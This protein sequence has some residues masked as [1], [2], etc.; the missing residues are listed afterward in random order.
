MSFIPPW[1]WLAVPLFVMAV[2]AFRYK[3]V[4][5]LAC[6]FISLI[7]ALGQSDMNL[8]ALWNKPVGY[9]ENAI[10]VFSWNSLGWRQGDKTKW[11]DYIAAHKADIIL[12]QE[13]IPP[14]T[15]DTPVPTEL[16][17]RFPGYSLVPHGEW[18]TITRF[19]VVGVYGNEGQF[20]LRTDVDINSKRVSI[21]NIHIPVHMDPSRFLGDPGDFFADMHERHKSRQ[22]QFRLLEAELRANTYP[23]II[24]GDFNS[25]RSMGTLG[26]MADY[27]E[28]GALGTDL[29][30]ATW[31][32]KGIH[33]WRIDWAY[34]SKDLRALTYQTLPRSGLSDHNAMIFSIQTKN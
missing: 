4:L 6:G 17:E 11:L 18:L 5:L 10:T 22:E 12:L 24:A 16:K 26:F 31:G 25:T 19:P 1:A 7:L 3:N 20:W 23:K 21:Y 13:I 15:W 2:Y 8:G 27:T 28:V 14:R 34:V 30:P 29:F 32:D 9:Q 33:L